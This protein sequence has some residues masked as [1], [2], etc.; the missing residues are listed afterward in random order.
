MKSSLCLGLV[1]LIF[2]GT[3]FANQKKKSFVFEGA[4]ITAVVES[5]R[6]NIKI[7]KKPV[8]VYNWSDGSASDFWKEEHTP[9]EEGLVDY[10]QRMSLSFWRNY[11]QASGGNMYGY[12]LYAAIDP[13]VTNSYGG[14]G[15][16]WVLLQ[17]Q[18][19]AGFKFI[20]AEYSV[21]TQPSSFSDAFVGYSKTLK[22]FAC[23]EDFLLSSMFNN[24]GTGISSSC[25]RL[26]KHIFQEIFKIDGFTYSYSATH[27]AACSREWNNSKAFVITRPQWMN[28]D[29]IRFYSSKTRTNTEERIR[30][31]TIFLKNTAASPTEALKTNA[32]NKLK[33][34]MKSKPEMYVDQSTTKCS[35][36]SCTITVHFCNENDAKNCEDFDLDPILRPGGGL[37]TLAEARKTI[38]YNLLWPDL[39]G[40]PKATTIEV[41]LKENLYACSGPAPYGNDSA[42][43]EGKP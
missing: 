29:N 14:S 19:P 12:G 39:E 35:A 34:Y 23:P 31:Q 6:P 1:L 37:I 41:W 26:A 38:P 3:S 15:E 36:D 43:D 7:L 13:V 18:L 20:D 8:V 32:L 33:T 17:M 40:K 4:D 42:N 22:E 11:G 24:A 5:L 25:Q 21:G 10:A 2:S 9:N 30:I 27:F 28:S 16:D